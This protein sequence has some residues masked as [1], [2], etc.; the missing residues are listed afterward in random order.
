MHLIYLDDSADEKAFTISALAIP[1]D[2]W[3]ESFAHIRDFRRELRDMYGIY[4]YKELHAW[5][6]V[7]GRGDISER[8]ITKWERS[9]IF[10][11]TL[12]VLALIPGVQV[13]N[14]VSPTKRF[15]TAFERLL[16]RINRTLESW[17][18]FGIIVSDQGKEVAYTRIVRKLYVYNPIPSKY[19]VWPDT[20][21]PYKNIPLRRLAEDPF[22][23]DS[24]ASYFVQLAD[25]CAYAL[26]RK[27]NPVP[28]KSK[29]G[30]DTAFDLL[31]QI[32]VHAA[33]PRDPFGVIRLE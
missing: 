24:E 15:Q 23:K 28:S 16:N 10:R 33:N 18:S 29:Y 30:L 6:F 17:G 14:C 21:M 32:V 11:R 25:F 1:I 2:S 12:E 13:F 27:E 9:N 8:I 20:Q 4:M 7:S 31:A 26:L 19:G 22:F 3:H 5:K